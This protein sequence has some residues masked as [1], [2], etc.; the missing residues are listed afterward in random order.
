VD[1]VL[2][3]DDDQDFVLLLS[4]LLEDS[5]I[6]RYDVTTACSGREALAMLHHTRP[7]LVLL[8]L[9]MPDVSGF[10]VIESMRSSPE[11]EQIPVVVVSGQDEVDTFGSLSA[12]LFVTKGGDAVSAAI[13]QWIQAVVDTTE[14]SRFSLE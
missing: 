6:R 8:D 13:V 3:V 7:D 1:K 2:V 14:R 11:F 12:N 10:E 4:R 9:V 5:P